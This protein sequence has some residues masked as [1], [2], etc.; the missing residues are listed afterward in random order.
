MGII[1]DT[2]KE[3]YIHFL[4][5]LARMEE[6]IEKLPK[7]T[8]TVKKIAGA[9]YYYHQWR[10]GERVVSRSLGPSFPAQLSREIERRKMLEAQQKEV[11]ENLATISRAIHIE[12]VTAEAVIEILSRAGVRF[13]LAG[14]QIMPVL[15]EELEFDL[16]VIRTQDIDILIER[17]Y[18]GK[19][20]DIEKS[21]AP[22][23]FRIG[24]HPDGATYFTNGLFR[25]EFITP[26]R[27][28]GDES[29]VPV[30]PLGIRAEPLRYLQILEE[31][32]LN[33]KRKKYSFLVP[34]P[35]SLAVH[36]MLV[37]ERRKDFAKKK[38]DLLQAKALLR[39]IGK[40]RE[41]AEEFRRYFASLPAGW[42]KKTK[43][44]LDELGYSDLMKPGAKTYT[45]EE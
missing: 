41:L 42:R 19:E 28:K 32:P 34:N 5:E 45:D 27:G 37:A 18:R 20:A 1:E 44:A 38:K 35:V 7:G 11:R 4:K 24:F 26:E 10:E 22:L 8:I 3:D 30:K 16:P 2:L 25:V 21:L 29:S 6:D 23:G 33:V 14:S 40:N 15:K 12:T 13:V 39:E 17:P 43:S 36:K 31:N 9:V